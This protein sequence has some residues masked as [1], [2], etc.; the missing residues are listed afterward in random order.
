MAHYFSPS[1]GGF[2]SDFV[3]GPRL[4]E[5]ELTPREKKAGKRPA[6]IPNPR[7]T[8]PADAEPISD[9]RMAELMQA[10]AAGKEITAVGNRP[11][12][13]ER[14][15]D[16]AEQREARRRRRDQLLAASDWTQ[17]TDNPLDATT[18]SDWAAYRRLLRDLDMDVADW[19]VAPGEAA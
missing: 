3:N 8:L 10:Q 9:D 11:V 13:I 7:C 12:A 4:I 1:T 18:R 5:A 19:P 6:M 14:Q 16:P 2:Y 17:L 15:P